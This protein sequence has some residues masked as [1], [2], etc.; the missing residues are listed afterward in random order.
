MRAEYDS[1]ANAI[2]ITLVEGARADSADR[3]HPRAVVALDASAPVDVELLSP[4]EGIEEPLQ[5]VAQ[6]YSLDLEALKAATHSALDAPDR[7]VVL[8][9]LERT[10][11]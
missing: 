7:Q 5:S 9:V 6:K 1:E 8:E 11:H 2:A 10:T 3:V 4:D